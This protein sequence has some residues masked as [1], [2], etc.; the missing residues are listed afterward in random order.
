MAFIIGD[1]I[2]TLNDAIVTS[3]D[4]ITSV[5]VNDAI[6]TSVDHVRRFARVADNAGD[7]LDQFGAFE[8]G[9]RSRAVARLAD[10]LADFVGGFVDQPAKEKN[11]MKHVTPPA[12]IER[13]AR[14]LATDLERMV[15][16]DRAGATP[17][18]R[19]SSAVRYSNCQRSGNAP[20]VTVA[21][22]RPCPMVSA[23]TR[24]LLPAMTGS[25]MKLRME[26]L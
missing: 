3:V 21:V 22:H 16:S 2:D 5:D 25:I 13:R 19:R 23:N 18:R 4:A 11:R 24:R 12:E 6:V 7:C 15:A 8:H 14:L 1:A 20:G 9:A 10:S 26:D 17:C